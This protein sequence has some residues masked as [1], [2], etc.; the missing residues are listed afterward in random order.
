MCTV[1]SDALSAGL[2]IVGFDYHNS[3][4]CWLFVVVDD[5]SHTRK[6]GKGNQFA[7]WKFLQNFQKN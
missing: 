1:W 2:K 6:E 5:Y 7:R 3:C 4:F